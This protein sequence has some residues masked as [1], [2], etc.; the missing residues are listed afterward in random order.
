[1]FA[2][3]S[4]EM[5]CRRTVFRNTAAAASYSVWCANKASLAR[6]L[7]PGNYSPAWLL[8]PWPGPIHFIINLCKDEE[9]DT[10]THTPCSTTFTRRKMHQ[11][12]TKAQRKLRNKLN[13][14]AE[15]GL[16]QRIAIIF[17][18]MYEG[19]LSRKAL[20]VL[21][22]LKVWVQYNSSYCPEL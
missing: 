16:H 15:R 22:I 14:L 3:E 8:S 6:L 4:I 17:T 10:S 11:A 5:L 20:K 7:Y 12:G 1:M 21:F 19:Q 13:N 2:L 9:T 18:F